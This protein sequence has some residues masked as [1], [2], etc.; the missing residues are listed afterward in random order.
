VKDLERSH[1]DII[2]VLPLNFRIDTEGNH[3]STPHMWRP[4]R[5]SSQWPLEY[6]FSALPL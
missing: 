3:N 4:S 1:R 5:E 2:E 6:D